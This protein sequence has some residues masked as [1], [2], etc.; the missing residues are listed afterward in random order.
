MSAQKFLLQSPTN[1]LGKGVRGEYGEEM[2]ITEY[3][4]PWF[5]KKRFIIPLILATFLIIG[6]L[7][8]PKDTSP[9]NSDSKSAST[10]TRSYPVTFVNSI[11]INPATLSVRFRIT[12]DGTQPI[13]PSCRIRAYD[14][15]GTYKG[16]DIFE[17]TN[18]IEPGVSQLIG[19]QLTI[20]K[21]GAEFVTEFSGECTATT[22]DT[23]TSAGK[24]VEII[25]IQDGSDYD[26]EENEWYWGASFKGKNISPGTQMDCTVKALDSK[27]NVLIQRTYRANTVNNGV[28]VHYGPGD[29]VE[30]TTKKIVKSIKY[31]DVTCTL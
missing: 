31:F 16:F 15:S 29:A 14:P 21:E 5:K 11:V 3:R 18:P 9:N 20:T 2:T 13:T 30:V 19:G 12:N 27:N 8:S 23:G 25:D 7:T 1:Y 24:M 28:I 4:K 22:S 10:S 26:S 17:I 6:N